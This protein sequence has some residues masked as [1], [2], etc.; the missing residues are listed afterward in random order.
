MND[1]NEYNHNFKG[2]YCTCERPY[3]DPDNDVDDQMI[4]CI[5]CEDW[6]HGRVRSL[7]FALMLCFM[8]I[9]YI[10]SVLFIEQHLG[11]LPENEDFAEMICIS[12]VRRL[13]FL[14]LYY[15]AYGR[16]EISFILRFFA[17][18]LILH[19]LKQRLV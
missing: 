7:L 13:P 3:P 4:Q 2:T 10:M 15:C 18:E 5:A 9:M 6:F 8:F 11:V 12:C 1:K 14:W 19:F 17:F 16:S